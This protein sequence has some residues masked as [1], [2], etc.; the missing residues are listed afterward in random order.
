M[1]LEYD[2]TEKNL[3]DTQSIAVRIPTRVGRSV[4][5]RTIVNNFG[6]VN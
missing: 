6:F 1:Y 5:K 4:F 2:V 3:I